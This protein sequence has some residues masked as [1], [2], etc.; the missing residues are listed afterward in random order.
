MISKK[1]LITG[2]NGF[3]GSFLVEEGLRKG[4][5]IWAAVRSSSDLKYLSDKRIQF[6]DL[7]Y[8]SKVELKEQ[9]LQYKE[10]F[11]RW[12]YI[13]HNLGATKAKNSK[14]FDRVNYD[15]TRNFV[16]ALMIT[17][18]KPDKFVLMSSLSVCG[19]FDEKGSSAI[20]ESFAPQPNTAYGVSKIKAEQY[21]HSTTDFPYM[22]LRPTGV[23]GP[24]EKDYFLM[25]RTIAMG[26][27]FEVGYQP[28]YL[29]FIYV[30][31][32]VKAA[33]LAAESPLIAKTYFVADG[34]SYLGV[35]F[36]KLVQK[37]LPKKHLIAVRLPLA[38]VKVISLLS[39]K[40]AAITG[41]MS[42]L[43]S[44]KY[45][46]I[47]QRNWNCDISAIK[48]ELGYTPEYDLDQGLQE[49]IEWYKQHKWLK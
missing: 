8:S 41:K 3:I 26:F 13:I 46:I 22:I 21:L 16:E 36:R 43:N 6:I 48:R 27:D 10:C 24:R 2:A 35:D 47:K 18:M 40:W 30:K 19:P 25:I 38:F 15:F 29:S 32:L 20:T 1:V 42:T 37:K 17:D 31:D 23:Y 14:E 44:D 12:D 11:G 49:S 7:N 9:L 39:E 45:K 5:D 34:K 33:Y 4:F 28:Q